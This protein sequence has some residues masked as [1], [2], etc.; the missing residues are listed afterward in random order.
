MIISLAKA[1]DSNYKIKIIGKRPG[2]KLHEVMCPMDES[3]KV[4]EFKKYFVISPSSIFGKI[5]N[6]NYFNSLKGEKGKKVS[7]DF[8][9]HSGNNKH[10]L[11]VGEIKLLNRKY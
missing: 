10:F 5:L 4:I 11:N 6:Y 2:E 3:E 7:N 1:L 9:Y 8:E